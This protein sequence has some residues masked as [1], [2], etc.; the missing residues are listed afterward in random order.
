MADALSEL[1]LTHPELVAA[2]AKLRASAQADPYPSYDW[3]RLQL[4]RL[5]AM[6]RA[7]ASDF[8]QA[9]AEDF[10][11]R[12]PYDTKLGELWLCIN[13][14]QH[15]LGGLKGWMKPVKRGVNLPFWPASA[16]TQFQP[17]G[18]VGIIA[19]WNY[20]LMLAVQPLVGALAAGN[21]VMLKLSEHT[22]RTSRLL[23]Q[24]L[25]ETLGPD[26]VAVVLGDADVGAAFARL[27][28]DHLLFTGSSSVGQQVAR[29]AA[30]NL[31]PT[32]LELGG[33]CPAIL[34]A[35]FSVER[36][37]ARVVQGK[38]YSA[39]QS[40][41]APDYLL[42][43][44]AA[45]EAVVRA[46]TA[47][48][49]HCFPQ[50]VNN[51]D[52]SGILGATRRQRLQRLCDDAENRGA[53]RVTIN[54]AN[55]DF[56]GSGKLPLTLLLDVPGDARVL[57]E[58][59]FGPVLPVITYDTLDDAIRYVNARP[60]PLALYYF[61][62]EPARIRQVLERTLS[63]GVTINGTLMHFLNDDLPRGG[64]GQSGQGRYHG[65][66]GFMTF[67][68]EKAIFEQAALSGVGLFAPPY[69][70]HVDRVLRLLIGPWS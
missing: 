65:R 50:Q 26:L 39:G 20:P 60:S 7:S 29:A 59:V 62:S 4:Q 15:A 69:G 16:R 43:P 58:E 41:V 70:K 35:G 17:L 44:H 48:V 53:R 28:L 12:S 36:F 11:H 49:S 30:E 54:P 1:A 21:R 67:S 24:R 9:I 56:A 52:Y 10:G 37:A 64:V 61:D 55:E 40:C 66:Y 27:P 63:G 68:H 14:L 6:L 57:H 3:R 22:E 47:R 51:P 5:L 31:V 23:A 19:P 8:I 25:T 45:T 46:L 13:Q 18:V 34:H 2:L 38:C 42:V 33:K 32:T